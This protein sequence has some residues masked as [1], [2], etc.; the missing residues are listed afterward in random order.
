[1]R[2]SGS[3]ANDV[4]GPRLTTLVEQ[5]APAI[6]AY[7]ARRVDPA[8]DAADLL[9]ETML[10]AWKAVRKIPAEDE[11]ARMWLF[12]IARNHLSNYRRGRLRKDSLANR[13]RDELHSQRL[14]YEVGAGLEVREAVAQLPVEL[15]ELVTLVYW[16]GFT[17]E[18]AA[19]LVK[20]NASTARSRFAKARGML[21]ITLSEQATVPVHSAN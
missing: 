3:R 6:L 14:S 19:T 16:D 13:L 21:H 8:E 17:I 2:L 5:N 4:D 11:A 10:V 12:G 9:S 20:V 1:M 18:Q 7:F 15:Q